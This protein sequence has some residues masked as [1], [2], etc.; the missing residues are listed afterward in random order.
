M[1]SADSLQ[2]DGIPVEIQERLLSAGKSTNV[3]GAS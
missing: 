3:H 2:Q 1:L